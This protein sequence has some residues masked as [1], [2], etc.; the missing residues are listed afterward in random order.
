M[1]AAAA[2][3]AVHMAMVL[4]EVMSTVLVM[5]MVCMSAVMAVLMRVSVVVVL[6]GGCRGFA[7]GC[8]SL[9]MQPLAACS[10]K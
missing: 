4:V 10:V 9:F 8:Q 7:R 3:C 6:L 1:A 5:H 2:V